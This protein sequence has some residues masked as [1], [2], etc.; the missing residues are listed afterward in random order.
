MFFIPYYNLKISFFIQIYNYSEVG[1]TVMMLC[2]LKQVLWKKS[3]FYICYLHNNTKANTNVFYFLNFLGKFNV[4]K[5][6]Y[7]FRLHECSSQMKFLKLKRSLEAFF[8]IRAVIKIYNQ[9]LTMCIYLFL[10]TAFYK[11][12]TKIRSS[13]YLQKQWL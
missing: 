8:L 9:T 12:R 2:S 11:V 3:I 13:W 5:F 10:K 7:L 4:W 1:T 6:F